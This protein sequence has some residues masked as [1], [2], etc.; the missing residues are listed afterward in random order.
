MATDHQPQE[1]RRENRDGR[2]ARGE[3]TRR[4]IVESHA[5]LLREGELRPT[6]KLVSERAGISVRA[7]WLNFGDMDALMAATG[8]YWLDCDARLRTQVS[9]DLPLTERIE[10]WCAQRCRRLEDLA[11][12]A[13]S[14]QLVEP[15]SPS[16]TRS[17]R[18]HFD[19][20]HGDLVHTFGAE[21]GTGTD[22]AS[23]SPLHMALFGFSTSMT[24]RV[25]R[26]DQGL[27]VEEAST[28]LRQI[29]TRLLANP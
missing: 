4:A 14:A 1:I 5:A 29:F 11:P 25:L 21:I 7:L 19:R 17:R 8:Q 26:R 28:L 18:A 20:L 10:Q 3:R 13:A 23:A 2:V 24:W 27:S 6:A 15:F 12:A 22:A 16:L 9:P